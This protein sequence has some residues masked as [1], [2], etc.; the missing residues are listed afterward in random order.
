MASVN[1]PNLRVRLFRAART[2]PGGEPNTSGVIDAY[3]H[4]PS[5]GDEI[6]EVRIGLDM[7]CFGVPADPAAGL[8]CDPSVG[9]LSSAPTFGSTDS[10]VLEPGTWQPAAS[11]DCP[12]PVPAGM[13]CIKGGAFL[14]GGA[15]TLLG[16]ADSEP[17]PERLVRISPFALDETEV[18]V[19]MLAPLEPELTSLPGAHIDDPN[20]PLGYCTYLGADPS[21][22]LN[23]VSRTL[24]EEICAARGMRLPTEAEWEW[25]AGS[26]EE[27]SSFAWG[28]AGDLCSM[29]V[30]GRSPLATETSFDALVGDSSCRFQ[31]GAL[32]PP[33]PASGGNPNDVTVDGVRD[34]TGNLSE[35]VQD[36]FAGYDDPCWLPGT[37]LLED[38]V[39][40]P[41]ASSLRSYRGG[42][43]VER[44][45]QARAYQRWSLAS[46]SSYGPQHGVRCAKSF[47]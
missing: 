33:G 6:D 34:M 14:L 3:G 39:C 23:C 13:R 46:S 25:A 18:S 11:V 26:R 41:A 19:Q 35:W 36:G 42:S 4:L 12:A 20:Q 10:P 15:T 30:L 1:P 22:P 21:A 43:W 40:S 16:Q 5:L 31:G 45:S 24:A 17:A 27:E 28:N 29:A 7:A 2:N 8:S 32:L 37:A 38:P 44:K 9:T 47:D